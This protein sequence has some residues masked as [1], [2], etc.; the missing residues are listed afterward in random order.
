MTRR[1]AAMFLAA[2]VLC[3]CVILTGCRLIGL[4]LGA[5][6]DSRKKP[7]TVPGWQVESVPR[8]SA[9]MVTARDGGVIGGRYDGITRLRPPAAL[10]TVGAIL[11]MNDGFVPQTIN[12]S[13]PDREC[14]L[15]YVPG[16]ALRESVNVALVCSTRSDGRATAI[17]LRR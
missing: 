15:D 16:Q 5:F 10:E 7:A 6:A 12:L 8:G 13:V 4:G 17:L 14:D 11:A 2:A 9:V 1:P 3:G